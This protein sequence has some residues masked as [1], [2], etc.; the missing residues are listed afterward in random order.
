MKFVIPLLILLLVYLFYPFRDLH[1]KEDPFSD[2]YTLVA[3]GFW[4]EAACVEAAEAQAA[5]D[6]RCRKRSAWGGMFRAVKEYEKDDRPA[7]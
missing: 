3:R 1:V 2:A 6:F 5:T 4:T 7:P